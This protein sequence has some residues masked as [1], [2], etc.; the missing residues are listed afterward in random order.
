[1]QAIYFTDSFLRKNNRVEVCTLQLI[2]IAAIILA[3][4]I[5]EDRILS[6]Q[7]G[8]FECNNNYSTEM[9][10]KTERTMLLLLEFQTNLPTPMDFLQFLLYTSNQNFDFSPII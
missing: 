8:E 3:V 4:K 5:N 2:G 7:Q 1:M 9:I 6:L 10:E